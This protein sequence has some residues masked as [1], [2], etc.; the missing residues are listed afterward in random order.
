MNT[1]IKAWRRARELNRPVTVREVFAELDEGANWG[2]RVWGK[3]KKAGAVVSAGYGKYL[4]VDL[5]EEELTPVLILLRT[6]DY[7]RSVEWLAKKSGLNV[8][9][10]GRVLDALIERDLVDFVLTKQGRRYCAC[11]TDS[12]SPD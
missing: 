12:W 10:T 1:L 6:S 4:A 3:L 8:E 2:T 7:K 9:E 11:F 5:G